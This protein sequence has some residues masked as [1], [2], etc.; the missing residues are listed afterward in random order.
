[1]SRDLA[2]CCG[3][4]ESPSER[5]AGIGRLNGSHAWQYLM[6]GWGSAQEGWGEQR[7][8]H[9]HFPHSVSP[10]KKGELGKIGVC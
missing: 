6:G 7:A 10:Q 8:S 2:W 5:K 9:Q 3:V 1:M 4:E